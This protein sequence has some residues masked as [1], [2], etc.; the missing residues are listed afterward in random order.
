MLAGMAAA[1]VLLAAL[2]GLLYAQGPDPESPE[3]DFGIQWPTAAQLDGEKTVD[4]AA[5]PAGS[6]L[7][8]TLVI[9]NSGDTA[10]SAVYLTDTLPAG[11]TYVE[12]SLIVPAGSTSNVAGDTITWS[13]QVFA[14]SSVVV[15]FDA[16]IGTGVAVDEVLENMME[17]SG[18]DQTVIRTASTTVVMDTSGAPIFLPLISYITPPIPPT[19]TA[20]ATLPNS[21]NQWT[22]SWTLTGGDMEDLA[23]VE[24]HESQ[25]PTFDT[26]TTYDLAADAVSQPILQPAG[27]NNV[28]YYRVQPIGPWGETGY[29][30]VVTVVGNYYDDFSNPATGWALRRSSLLTDMF[31]YYSLEGS[32]HVFIALVD[33]RWD[34]L[35]ASPL[36]PAPA[37]PYVIEY[38]ARA[39]DASNLISGGIVYGGN[40]NG[41][42]CPEQ[43]TLF[44]TGQNCF[45]QFYA[46]NYIF[47]G[48]LK[49]Q[50][51]KVNELVYCPSCGGSALKRIAD[52]D[53]YDDIIAH[54]QS[55][56]WNDYRI[57]VRS[58]GAWVYING[59]FKRHYPDTQYVNQPYFGVF[60]STFEYKPAIWFFDYFRITRMD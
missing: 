8:Y 46:H 36:R 41:G 37:I 12:D 21:S 13:G 25:S 31:A 50:W 57:E 27:P 15:E 9:S 20:S 51:E 56:T 54:G 22:L 52:T 29:S 19:V 4:K 24:L 43:G 1:V 40:W 28:F 48:P 3:R 10:F 45:S 14:S 26:Y 17:V 47:Y 18:E 16:T 23:A 42:Q 34:W 55:L 35:L 2:T 53:I 6:Q 44:F 11:L 59:A 32:D 39:H 49:L 5:A 58:D 30:D 38:R 33:D 7:H 60:A